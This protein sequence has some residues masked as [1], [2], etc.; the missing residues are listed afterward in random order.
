MEDYYAFVAF[1]Q[2]M[3]SLDQLRSAYTPEEVCD[4]I[5]RRGKSSVWMQAARDMDWTLLLYTWLFDHCQVPLDTEIYISYSF[6]GRP[7]TMFPLDWIL[8]FCHWPVQML[9]FFLS[10]RAPTRMGLDTLYSG[11]N[12]QETKLRLIEA[13]AKPSDPNDLC[14]NYYAFR[15]DHRAAVLAWL[16]VVAERRRPDLRR[17]VARDLWWLIGRM[18]WSQCRAQWLSHN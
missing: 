4:V 15:Q 18:M 3:P 9:D 2:S 12:C 17:V 11:C 8:H 1:I 10:R 6:C 13:G 7:S 16:S 5:K 14:Y